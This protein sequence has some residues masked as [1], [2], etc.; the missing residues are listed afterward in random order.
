MEKSIYSQ[1]MPDSSSILGVDYGQEKVG[2]AIADEEINM[3]F[4]FCALK[5]GANFWDELGKIIKKKNVHKMVI[6]IPSHVNRVEV[7]YPGE[8]FADEVKKRFMM[9]IYFQDEMFTTKMAKANLIAKGMRAVD[10]HDDAE[11][12]RIIL[13]SWLDAKN[14]DTSF[15][16]FSSF[17]RK[18]THSS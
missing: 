3:A 15:L 17:T 2:I 16:N 5:N 9:E 11:A 6:G 1:D 8:K 10:K 18:D 13:Q 4:A 14:D 12:A 7:G